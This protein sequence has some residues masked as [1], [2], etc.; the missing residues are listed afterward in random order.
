M[1]GV[2]GSRICLR[3]VRLEILLWKYSYDEQKY[4]VDSKLQ[5]RIL[6][7]AVTRHWK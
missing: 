3:S 6:N 1:Y 2:I 5:L 7:I 4:W